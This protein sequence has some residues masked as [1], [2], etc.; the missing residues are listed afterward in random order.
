MFDS[1]TSAQT[2]ANR[3]FLLLLLANLKSRTEAFGCEGAEF[4]DQYT[5]CSLPYHETGCLEH[6]TDHAVK[7]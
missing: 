2:P 5:S 7:R 3:N 4:L 1:A 6:L